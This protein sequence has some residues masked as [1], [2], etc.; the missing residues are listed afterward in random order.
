MQS[1]AGG[2]KAVDFI[3]LADKDD[4][5]W[6]IEVKDYRSSHARERIS[7]KD[8]ELIDKIV[9]DVAK[10]VRHSIAA[11]VIMRARAGD[12]KEADF[13]KKT[14]TRRR[15]RVAFHVELPPPE[16]KIF[17]NFG[18]LL[19]EK[20]NRAIS[21]VDGDPQFGDAQRAWEWKI[22]RLP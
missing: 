2:S 10:K 19:R 11:L 22:T 20:F 15:P 13:A 9:I 6:L 3:A 1:F 21:V 4:A 7:E 18:L 17:K 5:F 16:D 14:L 8:D 12:A